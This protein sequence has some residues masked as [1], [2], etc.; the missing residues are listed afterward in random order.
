[1]RLTTNRGKM[2]WGIFST[3]ASKKTKRDKEADGGFCG[4]PDKRKKMDRQ[5]HDEMLVVAASQK[6][7]KTPAKDAID[8]FKNCLRPRARTITTQFNTLIRIACWLGNS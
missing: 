2:W 7:G 4:Q 6:G 1:L 3:T 5:R 8:H